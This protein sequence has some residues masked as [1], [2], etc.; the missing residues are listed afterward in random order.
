LL[1]LNTHPALYDDASVKW[2]RGTQTSLAINLPI[3]KSRTLARSTRT[4]GSLE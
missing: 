2:P 4:P 3:E 1:K